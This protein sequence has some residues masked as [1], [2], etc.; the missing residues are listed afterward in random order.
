MN[1]LPVGV[2]ATLIV[3]RL[4]FA[5]AWT[6]SY[7]YDTHCDLRLPRWTG[8]FFEWFEIEELAIWWWTALLVMWSVFAAGRWIVAKAYAQ[9]RWQLL[10]DRPRR[11]FASCVF[12]LSVFVAGIRVYS[13]PHATYVDWWRWIGVAHQRPCGNRAYFWRP[14]VGGE[15]YL[16]VPR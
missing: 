6:F 12:L 15:W 14:H 5:G 7:G 9:P 8:I 11:R 1:A 3:S 4:P 16:F 10:V 2:A 13:C